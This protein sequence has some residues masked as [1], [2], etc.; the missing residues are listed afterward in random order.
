MFLDVPF[1]P[2]IQATG[3]LCCRGLAWGPT[4]GLKDIARFIVDAIGQPN[5]E[6][7]VNEEAGK[8]FSSDIDAFER[9]A[10]TGDKRGS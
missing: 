5:A 3:E 7:F 2:S 1:H 4:K 10:A 9:R 8:L 6:S